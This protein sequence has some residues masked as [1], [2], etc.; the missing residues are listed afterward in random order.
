VTEERAGRDQIEHRRERAEHMLHAYRERR[1][2][3]RADDTFFGSAECL[4]SHVESG[5]GEPER[6]SRRIELLEEAEG[7]G[8][9]RDL[10]E[11]IYEVAREEG[12]D[13]AL[14]YE[15]VRCGLGVV[16]PS[17]GIETASAQPTTD[18]YL[19]QWMFP[20]VPTDTVLRERMLRFSFRRLRGLLE[21]HREVDLAFRAFADEPDVGTQGY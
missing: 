3:R 5:I 1:R 13:P 2:S 19:P 7:D 11:R 21:E 15:L 8:M 6:S 4:L 14:G 10:A 16:P 18:K 17:D 9:S 20:P 12:I